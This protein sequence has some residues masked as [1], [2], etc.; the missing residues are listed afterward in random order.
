MTLARASRWILSGLSIAALAA[1]VPVAQADCVPPTYWPC[2]TITIGTSGNDTYTGG[3][4]I[5]CILSQGGNDTVNGAGG[6]DYLQG[7]AGDDTLD[8]DEGDDFLDGR[9]D[10]DDLFG[11][12]G[13]DLLMG[14]GGNDELYGESG[15]DDLCGEDGDDVLVGGTTGSNVD[16]LDGGAGTDTCS[17]GETYVSCSP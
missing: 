10:N 13:D 8:G 4:G 1:A 12:D 11:G 2:E 17:E 16:Y 9:N 7:G 14:S 15:S 3:A 5:D 6:G